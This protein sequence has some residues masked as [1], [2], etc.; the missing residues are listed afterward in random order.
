MMSAPAVDPVLGSC[1]SLG[2]PTRV[3]SSGG[4]GGVTGVAGVAVT[5]AD[6]GPS[7]T[8][9]V[10]TTLN[11]YCVPLISP[12]ITHEVAP[13]VVHVAAGVPVTV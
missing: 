13:V 2:V 6:A 9:L 12:V 10:A 11:V 1:P 7:P 3:A 4:V 8:A 5:L